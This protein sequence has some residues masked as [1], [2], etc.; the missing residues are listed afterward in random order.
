MQAMIKTTPI[1]DWHVANSA[2]MAPFGGY[3]MPIWYS[4]IRD[5]HLNVLSKAGIF[6]TSHMS[7][8]TLT[9]K[10]SRKLLQYCFSRDLQ[11]C[12]SQNSEP[13]QAGQ[14]IYG[15]FLDINGHVLDDA[16]LYQLS[17]NKYLIIV[18][19]GMG[20]I[21]AAHLR[22][23]I[24]ELEVEVSDLTDKLGKIDIQG[25]LSATILKN[26][27]KDPKVVFN[28]FP[29]FTF[30]GNIEGESI[31]SP[32]VLLADN[33]PLFLS[34]SG[35][36]G[37]FGFEIL[38]DSNRLLKVWNRL[39]ETGKTSGLLPCGLAARDSLRTGAVLPLSHQDIGPWPFINNPWIFALPFNA[40]QSD[41]TKKFIG[42]E[43]LKTIQEPEYT[44]PFVGSDL[45]KINTEE[46]VVFNNQGKQ[47]GKVLTCVTD[48]G[49]GF[50]NGRIYSINS[51]QKPKEFNPK[52]L[53]CGFVK[54]NT[55]LEKNS[56]VKLKDKRR[57]ITV[58]IVDDIRPDRTA[59][60]PLKEMLQKT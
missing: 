34:R 57:L 40:E 53:C 23:H 4:S 8:I 58:R 20:N 46:A 18:N 50:L 33:T 14:L 21:I 27:L 31:G 37:E 11:R 43:T 55:E 6:D 35:Y 28:K 1:H 56:D 9:G 2:S 30:K 54:V 15:V 41:F 39:L 47:I 52:G 60:K 3:N 7:W 36:T 45:R 13:L 5:E 17:Q 19:T 49:I 32:A 29:Y 24:N 42:D 51:P 38:V 44:Y 25:P 59:R 12:R 22:T 26:L 10:D 48:M 16:I